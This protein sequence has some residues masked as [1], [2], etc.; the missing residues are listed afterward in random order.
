MGLRDK[1]HARRGRRDKP[2]HPRKHS[3]SAEKAGEQHRA[4]TPAVG[5]HV[6]MA[7]TSINATP[8]V[9]RLAAIVLESV[10]SAPLRP[11]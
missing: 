11:A 4:V 5:Q 6:R 1:K 9:D 8:L 2:R 10:G 3:R 7:F